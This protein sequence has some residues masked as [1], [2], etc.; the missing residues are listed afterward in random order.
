MPIVLTA[1]ASAAEYRQRNGRLSTADDASLDAMLLSVS[2]AVDKRCGVHPGAFNTQGALT[3]VF[4]G[5]GGEY[6]PLRDGQGLQYFLRTI[7]TDGLT[8]D[9]DSDGTADYTLDLSDTF[10]RGLPENATQYSEPYTKLELL[11]FPTATVAQWPLYRASVSITGTWGWAAVP[12]AIKERVIGLTRELVDVHHSGAAQIV[13]TAEDLIQSMPSA[14]ALM[15]MLEREF[16]Y[17]IP[18]V[19]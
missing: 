3:F 7:S 4:D 19:A 13:S 2:R 6:L 17:R 16:S 9:T 5:D 18:G 15:N 8:L 11:P 10:V 12:G 1:Y 14:R